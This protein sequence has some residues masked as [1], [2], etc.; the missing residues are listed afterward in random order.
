MTD[1]A[2]A[3]GLKVPQLSDKTIRELSAIIPPQG[4]SVKN[5][6]DVGWRFIA[7]G[8]LPKVLELL[9][10]DPQVD[11]LIFMQP[12]ALFNRFGGRSAVSMLMK[13]TLSGQKI[14]N[15]PMILVVEKTDG[16]DGEKVESEAIERYRAANIAAFPDF[17]LA[18]RVTG[19]LAEYRA[20]L[21]RS[22]GRATD[23]EKVAEAHAS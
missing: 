7:G 21:N 19:Y 17:R 6:L 3:E 5:P 4:T 2:E 20:F 10:H 8:H 9:R 16:F 11:A 1:L 22:S 13:Q 15:K 23:I 18:V 12:L 14:L